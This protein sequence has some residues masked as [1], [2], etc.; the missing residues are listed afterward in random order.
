M[1]EEYRGYRPGDRVQMV[2]RNDPYAPILPGEKGPIAHIDDAGTLHMRWDD[3]R[4][5]GVCLEKDV[6]RKV[7][8]EQEMEL[9]SS[10][11]L[12]QCDESRWEAHCEQAVALTAAMQNY[13]EEQGCDWVVRRTF[14]D[15]VHS[16]R[17]PRYQHVEAGALDDLIEGT[18]DLKNG[19]DVGFMEKR[20]PSE[21]SIAIIAYG[22]GYT[23]PSG[24]HLVKELLELRL[25]SP[26]R[27]ARLQGAGRGWL[28]PGRQSR[29]A[30]VQLAG[31]PPI[32]CPAH[33]RMQ[34][35]RSIH[36][37]ERKGPGALA[38]VM[39]FL[40]ASENHDPVREKSRGAPFVKGAPLFDWKSVV[41]TPRR[42]CPIST[43]RDLR[44]VVGARR[45][46]AVSV[47]RSAL[48]DLDTSFSNA[49]DDAIAVVNP[50]AP[51]SG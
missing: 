47:M 6:V 4:T 7:P 29:H 40:L 33:P 13:A 44:L 50:A 24:T 22:Q 1:K 10:E 9:L 42:N 2:E 23:A 8:P 27:H 38:L 15:E 46:S 49:I 12:L 32:D 36:A 14:I 43:G 11:P 20:P 16:L 41:K 17:P 51:P 45:A 21:Q 18:C 30:A 19:T 35:I 39:R 28:G 26:R 25:A 37:S 3:G 34:G 31:R 5:L 48:D